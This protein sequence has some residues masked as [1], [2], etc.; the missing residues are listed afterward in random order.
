MKKSIILL[1]ILVTLVIA[2]TRPVR[3]TSNTTPQN[4]NGNSYSAFIQIIGG[5]EY[6]IADKIGYAGGI[7]ITHHAACTNPLHHQEDIELKHID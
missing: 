1:T 2:C 5:C 4:I 3:D 6:V 7:A